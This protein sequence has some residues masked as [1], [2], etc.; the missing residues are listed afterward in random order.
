MNAWASTCLNGQVIERRRRCA[1]HVLDRCTVSEHRAWPVPGQSR[2]RRRTFVGVGPA[3]KQAFSTA[4]GLSSGGGGRETGGQGR[5]S[6]AIPKSGPARDRKRGAPDA[7]LRLLSRRCPPGRSKG[8]NPGST[9]I[10]GPSVQA[11]RLPVRHPELDPGS[12]FLRATRRMSHVGMEIK[13]T[14]TGILSPEFLRSGTFR[15]SK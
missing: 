9:S 8:E 1:M 11:V 4:G 7:P 6:G 14:V 3:L 13:C 2:T 5:A 15:S 10:K 12:K